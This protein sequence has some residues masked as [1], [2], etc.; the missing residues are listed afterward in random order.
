[1]FRREEN[2]SSEQNFCNNFMAMQANHGNVMFPDKN[3]LWY[4]LKT[5][6]FKDWIM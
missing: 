3:A 4:R 6:I 5:Y 1:M 2:Y